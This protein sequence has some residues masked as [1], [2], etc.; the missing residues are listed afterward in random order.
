MKQKIYFISGPM[1]GIPNDNKV[2]FFRAER[3][4]KNIMLCVYVFNPAKNPPGL[5]RNQYMELCKPML[6]FSTHVYFLN[7]WR[8]SAGAL[9]E[10]RWA[11]KYH[12]KIEHQ[13]G[14]LI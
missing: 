12:L 4:L 7:G 3:W 10:Y 2:E 9:I 6:K 1:S 14:D 5:T 8:R 11:M 13:Q